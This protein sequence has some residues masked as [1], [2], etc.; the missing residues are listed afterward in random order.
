M[1]ATRYREDARVVEFVHAIRATAPADTVELPRIVATASHPLTDE[2]EPALIETAGRWL[3]GALVL[4]LIAAALAV[5]AA[6]GVQA[7]PHVDPGTVQQMDRSERVVEP[8]GHGG[9]L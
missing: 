6:L 7:A 4:L 1:I 3:F 5:V 8:S 2:P 9:A